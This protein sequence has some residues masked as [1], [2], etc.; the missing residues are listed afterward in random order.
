MLVGGGDEKVNT[1]GVETLLIDKGEVKAGVLIVLTEVAD[2]AFLPFDF[3]GVFL[4]VTAL[5]FFGGDFDF[6]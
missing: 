4:L 2:N 6:A 5:F 1:C 3:F